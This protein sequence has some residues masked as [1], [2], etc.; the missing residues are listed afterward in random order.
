MPLFGKKR[1]DAREEAIARQVEQW[2]APLEE[3]RVGSG[4][5]ENLAVLQRLFANVDLLQYRMIQSEAV[6]PARY[7]LV[8]CDG[9]VS[10]EIINTNI[11]RPLMSIP[12]R[13]GVP[14][15]ESLVGDILHVGG[16]K[17]TKSFR[18][19]V[20]SVTYGES[21]LFA[22]GMDRAIL[23]NTKQFSLRSVGE[24]DNEK[25]LM[26]PREGFTES[27]VSNLSQVLRRLRTNELKTRTLTLGRRTRTSVCVA[28]LDSLAKGELVDEILRRLGQLDI[29]GVLDSN[30]L[31]ELIRDHPHSPFRTV[32]YT[33]RP[34]AVVGKLLEGRVAIFVDGTPMV[35]T[36]P[37]LFIENFQSAEDYYLSFYYTS[38]SRIVRIVAFFLTV[39]MPGFYIAVVA[40][41]QEML[42][43]QLLMHIA[44]ERQKVPLP[45]AIEAV[46]ML[47]VFDV[48]RETGVRMPSNI[49]D[50]L[51]I[52]GALVIGQAAVEASLVAA[53]MIIVV[54]ATGITGLL[55]TKLNAPILLWRFI[56]LVMASC[57][58]FVGLTISFS[59]MLIHIYNLTSFGV[60][61]VLMTG[62]FRPQDVKDI[63]IRAPWKKMEQRPSPLTDN[64][65]RQG[66]ARDEE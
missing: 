11:V 64:L 34:D 51:S 29:D 18:E 1:R 27:M 60:E 54:A 26:G 25:V 7:L 41:H 5:E 17:Q 13:S 39:M 22:E 58:G 21:I 37:Y 36:A 52:V 59:L 20:E 48:L 44:Q 40:F 3:D 46:V 2:N 45:A 62:N 50:A 57:F 30:Y 9:V 10:S 16:V 8:F 19:I 14:L 61:E 43:L 42:P 55:V 28:Y 31:T 6:K 66:E 4:L 53:P 12:P 38:F 24:P 47:V 35:L 33:E 23:L 32:G 56:S 49:G 63:V 15:E 65:T